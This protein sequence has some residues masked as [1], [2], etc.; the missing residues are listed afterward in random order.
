MLPCRAQLD[1]VNDKLDASRKANAAQAAQQQ[2]H[3]QALTAL[4]TE[5]AE[6]EAVRRWQGAVGAVG[7]GGDVRGCGAL[8]AC[9][10]SEC[11]H[12]RVCA[13]FRCGLALWTRAVLWNLSEVCV[14]GCTALPG[15]YRRPG[16][17]IGS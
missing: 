5:C 17:T 15:A 9:P 2:E 8:A 1:A 14:R 10:G 7:G 12:S 6:H 4:Q 16:S 11:V 13:G 3:I